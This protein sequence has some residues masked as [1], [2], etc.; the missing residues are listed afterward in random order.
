MGFSVVAIVLA[1]VGVYGVLSLSVA[2]RQREIA[3]RMAVGGQRS[4]VLGLIL[5]E[6]MSL[7]A[8]GL[9]V[10]G[11]LGIALARVLRVL[12]FG[13]GPGDPATF[14]GGAIL[15]TA[16]AGIACW[17]PALRATKV[18]PTQALRSE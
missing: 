3:I 17:L 4:H 6:G 5:R 11:G 8:G 16:I 15:F 7:I 14:V 2:S 10:G 13:V 9:L 1:L 18:N 12:L